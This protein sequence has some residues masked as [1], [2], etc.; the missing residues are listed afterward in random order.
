MTK[1]EAA[2]LS[3]YT[4]FLIGDFSEMHEYVEKIMERA[5]WTHEFGNKETFDRIRE[6]SKPDFLEICENIRK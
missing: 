1:Y 3:A 6:L 2:V 4:G 5:V